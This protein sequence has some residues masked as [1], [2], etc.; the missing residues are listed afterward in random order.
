MSVQ[1]IRYLRR[2]E[3]DSTRWD[4]CIDTAPNGLIYAYSFY[5]DHM[6][7]HWDALVLGDYEAVMPLTWNKKWGIHYLYQPAFTAALGVFG[8]N[9]NRQI[10][11]QMLD[12]IPLKF[13]LIEI[14]LNSG[15]KFDWPVNPFRYYDSDEPGKIEM[16]VRLNF[17]LD[18]SRPYQE[19]YAGY[20]EN[21]KRNLKK[22]S[23]QQLRYATGIPGDEVLQL[24]RIQMNRVS[25][26][27]DRDFEN[28]RKLCLQLQSKGKAITCGVYTASNELAASAVFF[29]SHNRAYYILVGN[30]A[31]R[32][33]GA[34]HFLLDRFIH[35]HAGKKWLLDFEGSDIE[36]LAYFYSSFGAT[37][38]SYYS[39]R[40][41]QLPRWINWLRSKL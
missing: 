26:Y 16:N 33:E 31:N 4:H 9:L 34:S 2:A 25:D 11:N 23:G 38:E 28:F 14:E 18:L 36:G 37:E 15:N 3:I 8:K 10:V 24:A 21:L 32:T 40:A 17:V 29:Y 12:A 30:Q 7:R 39:A 35:D 6:S 13:R 1:S 5:L 22:S 27:S 19:L 20:R 41:S